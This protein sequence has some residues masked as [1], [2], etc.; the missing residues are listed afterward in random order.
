MTKY[1]SDGAV[2]PLRVIT[3]RSARRAARRGWEVPTTAS[4]SSLG[5]LAVRPDSPASRMEQR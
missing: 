1:E 4:G 3:Y 5:D 2:Q